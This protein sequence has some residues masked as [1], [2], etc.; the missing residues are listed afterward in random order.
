[1]ASLEDFIHK[2]RQEFD[3]DLPPERIWDRIDYALGPPT[4]KESSRRRPVRRFISIAAGVAAVCLLAIG[5]LLG[6]SVATH[7]TSNA[8]LAQVDPGNAE[9]EQ[10]FHHAIA[11]RLAEV[12]K[13]GLAPEVLADIQQLEVQM[14]MLEKAFDEAHPSQR[15]FIIHSMIRNYQLRIELL[16]KVLQEAGQ[17]W[18]SKSI[19]NDNGKTSI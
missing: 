7:R 5:M 6:I 14:G 11:I 16:E 3:S 9:T 19:Q 2:N 17:Q 18:P 15:E 13:A 4:Q 10:Y 12:R 8:V 1:M